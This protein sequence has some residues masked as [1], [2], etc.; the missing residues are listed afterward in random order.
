MTTPFVYD[1]DKKMCIEVEEE[2]YEEAV[3]YCRY[4]KHGSRE[5]QKK[6]VR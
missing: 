1:D 4:M 3:E 5:R 2:Q 6:K